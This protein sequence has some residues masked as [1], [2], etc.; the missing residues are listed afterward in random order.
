MDLDRLDEIKRLVIIAMF[1]D[2]DLMDVLVLKGGNVLDIVFGITPRASLD[3]DFSIE[4]E[5]EDP[6]EIRAKTERVLV[7]TFL[8]R[9]YTVFDVRMTE[10]PPVVTPDMK[11]F[12]GGYSVEFKLIET[13]RAAQLGDKKEKLRRHATVVGPGQSRTFSIDISKYEHCRPSQEEDLDGFTIQVYTPELIAF[14]KLRAICQQMPEYGA[15]V[16]S[17][18]QSARAKDFFDIYVVCEHFGIDFS[19]PRNKRL[20]EAIFRAKRVPLELIPRILEHREYHRQGFASL[21]D[22]VRR[23]TELREFDFYFDYVVR[24][25]RELHP[26]GDE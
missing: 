26:L 19:A 14:E 25:C 23:T 24:R 12:W 10:K 21:R 20:V 9:G 2:D 5:F 6:E 3:V 16:K 15:I 7:Q 17:R 1:S 4:R 18:S 22:T 8:E 13:G 11:D